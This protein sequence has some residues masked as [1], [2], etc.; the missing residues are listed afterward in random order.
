MDT[1]F[2]NIYCITNKVNNKKYIGQTVRTIQGR[3]GSHFNEVRYK[4]DPLHTAMNEY[5][6]ENFEIELVERCDASI[7]NERELHYMSEYATMYPNGYNVSTGPAIGFMPDATRDRI[8]KSLTGKVIPQEVRAKLSKAT[9]GIPKSSETKSKISATKTGR[10]KPLTDNGLPPYIIYTNHK[11]V[12]VGYKINCK[13]LKPPVHKAFLNARDLEE[14]YARCMAYYNEHVVHRLDA[15]PDN[16]ETNLPI[17]ETNARGSPG[18]VACVTPKIK[19]V[20]SS[21]AYS[22]EVKYACAK[23][24]YYDNLFRKNEDTPSMSATGGCELDNSENSA[25]A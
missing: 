10:P 23:Q 19:R 15:P 16:Q 6:V 5:G 14:A 1:H 12:R 17:Y 13:Y 25:T 2:G 22:M 24:W 20:F 18:Y 8:S 9:K 11:G 7:M 21:Q 4:T 3:L